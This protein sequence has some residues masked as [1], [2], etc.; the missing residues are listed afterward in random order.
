MPACALAVLPEDSYVTLRTT[1]PR[2][3]Y[4]L[5]NLVVLLL[6]ASVSIAMPA[7]A[8]GSSVSERFLYVTGMFSN[9]V[10][11]FAVGTDGT[12]TPIPGSPFAG[13]KLPF[14]I[15]FTP[16]GRHLYLSSLSAD[17]VSAFAVGQDGSLSAVPG[18]PYTLGSGGFMRTGGI[19]IS[20]DGKH[21]YAGS[22]SD[23]YAFSIDDDGSLSPVPGSPFATDFFAIGPF[24]PCISPDGKYLYASVAGQIRAFAIAPDGSLIKVGDPLKG[25]F[26]SILPRITPD[27]KH[28]YVANES[29]GSIS[30][31]NVDS[32]GTLTAIEGSPFRAGSVPHGPYPSPD[33][34][35]LYVPNYRSNG[36]SVYAILDDGKLQE[37]EGSPFK[38]DKGAGS[39]VIAPDGRTLYLTHLSL[40]SENDIVI[41]GIDN[42]GALNRIAGPFPTGVSFADGPATAMTPNQGPVAVFSGAVTARSISLNA[43]ASSDSDGHVVR[44]DWTFGDGAALADGGATPTHTYAQTGTYDVTLTV[45]DNEGCSTRTVFTGQAVSCN[46]SSRATVQHGFTVR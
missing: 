10:A 27:G 30:A 26:A 23:M 1:K 40:F 7:N 5:R 29:D 45:T 20:P 39:L 17:A 31:Y 36:I 38:S 13:G 22:G 11:G 8:A 46:G 2:K 21:L 33:G 6:A 41:F 14:N 3:K 43:T 25:L 35:F 24:W 37:I 18:S 16:D 15:Y 4:R 12:L 32:D 19:A 42:S 9:D 28:V 34:R 44:Y